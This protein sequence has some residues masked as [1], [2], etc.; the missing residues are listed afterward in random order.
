MAADATAAHRPAR[1]LAS[2]AQRRS[3]QDR[4]ADRRVADDVDAGIGDARAANM[5]PIRAGIGVS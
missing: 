5:P 1:D 3:R 2:T 4:S